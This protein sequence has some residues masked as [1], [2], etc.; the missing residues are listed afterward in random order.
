MK[1]LWNS[2]DRV[3]KATAVAATLW[4]CFV[5]YQFVSAIH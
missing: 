3:E 2:L 5:V 1:D 4:M